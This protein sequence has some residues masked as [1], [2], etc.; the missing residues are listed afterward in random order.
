[1]GQNIYFLK[2]PKFMSGQS[3]ESF[4][5]F[6]TFYKCPVWVSRGQSPKQWLKSRCQQ[7]CIPS[8]GSRG[9]SISCLFQLLEATASL[10]SHPDPPATSNASKG[11]CVSPTS[12]HPNLTSVFHLPWFNSLLPLWHARM[13]WL[14]QPHLDNPEWPSHLKVSWL[15]TLISSATCFLAEHNHKLQGLGRG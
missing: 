5:H 10:N 8:R 9:E 15:A 6:C 1:M 2:R 3:W 4:S 12:H 7:S 11:R 14:Y 13:C